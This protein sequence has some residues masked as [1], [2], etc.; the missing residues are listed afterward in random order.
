MLSGRYVPDTL[1]LQ[2]RSFGAPTVL[3][4]T[5]R[6]VTVI[7][8]QPKRL[9][10]LALLAVG[11]PEG[12]RRDLLLALFWPESDTDAA[13]NALRQALAMLR[14]LLGAATVPDPRGEMVRVDP[15]LLQTDALGFERAFEAGDL[16]GAL[17]LYRG[18]FLAGLHLSGLPE[19]ERW[20]EDRRATYRRRAARGAL[21]LAEEH[22]SGDSAVALSWAHRAIELAPHEEPAWRKLI[23]LQLERGRPAA[24]LA[25]YERLARM[26]AVDFDTTPAPETEALIA[27]LRRSTPG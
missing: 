20:I 26:L 6:P 1:M 17:A 10:L 5:G 2:L 27:G 18:E 4:E 23:A 25:S 24:A 13:R 11:Y 7:V 12:C 9:A 22:G 21:R 19:V 16:A 8:N 14:R 15:A 3:D